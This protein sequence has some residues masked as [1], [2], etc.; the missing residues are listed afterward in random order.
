MLYYVVDGNLR[1]A[2]AR[3]LGG[4][5]LLKCE[6]ISADRAQQLITMLTTS[7][8]F[9]PKDPLSM[10]LHFRRLIEE[11]GLSLTALC[12]ETGHSSPTLKSYL[13]LLDLDP[14]IQALVAKGKLP[15]SLRMSEAL[16]SVPE[17]GARVKLAQRLA[18][19]PGVTLT[20]QRCRWRIPW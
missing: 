19:R 5:M 4:D 18:Q 15:R 8:F 20:P 12:R 14:E 13:R 11:E 1:L 17:P 3:W 10:A 16:L 6:V 9:F 2:A 7:E